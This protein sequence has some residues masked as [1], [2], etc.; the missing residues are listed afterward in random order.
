MRKTVDFHTDF[1]NVVPMSL[2][3]I[4]SRCDVVAKS[5]CRI[6]RRRADNVC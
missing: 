5:T 6:P 4:Q 3:R 2:Y 1:V